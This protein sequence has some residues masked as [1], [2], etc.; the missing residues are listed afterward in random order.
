[1]KKIVMNRFPAVAAVSIVQLLFIALGVSFSIAAES[2]LISVR[3]GL[4]ADHSRIVLDCQGTLPSTIGPARSDSISVT[5]EGL[6]VGADLSRISSRLRGAVERIDIREENGRGVL[7]LSYKTTSAKTRAFLLKPEKGQGDRYRVVVDV[8]PGAPASTRKETP[9]PRPQAKPVVAATAVAAAPSLSAGD[10]A[11]DSDEKPLATPADT[12]SASEKTALAATLSPEEEPKEIATADQNDDDEAD[13]AEAS[14]SGEET[15]GPAGWQHTGE[16]RVTV[17]GVDGEEESAKSDEYRDISQPVYGDVKWAADKDR[18]HFIRGEATN[19]GRDDQ[20]VGGE[21]GSYGKYEVDA[22]YDSSIHRYAYD[23]KTLYS[24]V[25]TGMMTLSDALQANVQAAP[26]S[27]EI[28]N[29]L[30]GFLSS[31]ALGD[32]DVTRDKLKLGLNVFALDPFSFKVDLSHETRKGTRPYAGSFLST[33][34]VELFEPIDYE[35]LEMKISGEYASAP[36]YVNVAYHYS[37]FSNN[38]DTLTFDNPLIATDALLEPSSGRIDLAPDNQYHNV[39]L[40]GAYTKLPGNSQIIANAAWGVMLQDDKLVPFTTNTALAAPAL[41]ASSA[42]AKVYTSLYNLRL[43]SK[44]LPWMRIKGHARYYDYD[45]RT[46]TINF[47]NG[48]VETDAFVDATALTNL[49]SSYSK[50]RAGLDFGFDVGRR[51]GLGVG[52]QYERTDRENREVEEQDDHTFKLSADNRSLAWLDLRASYERTQRE[53]GD[54][55]F[56]VYLLSGDDLQQLPQL[57]KYDQ[58]DLARDRIQLQAAFLPTEVLSFGMSGIYGRDDY[59]ESPY[60]LL[61]DSHL[62]LSFD[63]DYAIS[64]RASV[65]LFYSFERYDN[66]QRGNDGTADWTA[67]GEDQ[68]HSVGAGLKLA[69]IP[70]LLDLDL[71][72]TYSDVDGNIAFTSPSGAFADFEAVDDT[73]IHSLNSKLKYHF[74]KNLTLSLGY[75]W[76]KFDYDDFSTNGFTFVPTNAAGNYQGALLAGTLPEDYDV[77]IV[78]T[79]LTFRY[80]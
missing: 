70:D 48:Y 25:G 13:E 45:N 14:D 22:S 5:F 8:F 79:Q 78:Y 59:K 34:M 30:N 74:T 52:Y 77:H 61:E 36:V 7:T 72:Y 67:D 19:I 21:A 28:A 66:T 24:G 42:D 32:P 16:V 53:I 38:I 63:A 41:P 20:S 68:V 6:D 1:M 73:K 4:H 44:P 50:T 23:A 35:T 75:L 12:A 69:L 33:E 31:A 3:E 46:G 56:D 58:A 17:Q 40:T 49:P 18:R 71:T 64:D 47:A 15:E 65:N 54:Y 60:G 76:E 11:R 2:K 9:A 80:H 27:A 55:N 37:Q 39:S 29:R 62:L 51:T 26:T 43:T 10:A 57:R